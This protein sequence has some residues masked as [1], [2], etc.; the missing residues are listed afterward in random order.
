MINDVTAAIYTVSTEGG[1]TNQ[2]AGMSVNWGTWTNE[3]DNWTAVTALQKTADDN[4]VKAEKNMTVLFTN[5]LLQIS[6]TGVALRVAPYVLMMAAGAVLLL[7]A[8]R[9]RRAEA[10]G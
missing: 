2:T 5:T 4:T 10:E 3:V 7:F 9:F 8:R 1:T 6:P